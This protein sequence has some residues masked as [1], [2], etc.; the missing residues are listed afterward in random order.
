MPKNILM[1]LSKNLQQKLKKFISSSFGEVDIYLF[2][3]RTDDSKK[4]GDIDFAID[5][6]VT[7]DIFKKQKIK[8]I[9]LLVLA[10][11]DLK[12]DLVQLSQASKLLLDEI[13]AEGIKL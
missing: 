11:Y 9:S 8:F 2:G 3:S 13:K 10:D 7:K 5:T 4:G 12:I 1:R 6:L